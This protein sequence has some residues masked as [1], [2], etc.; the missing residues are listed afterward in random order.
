ME[1]IKAQEKDSMTLAILKKQ[2]WE[3]TYRGIYPNEK[4]DNFNFESHAEKFKK[5][6]QDKTK[7]VYLIN[8]ENENVGYFCIGTPKYPLGD[9]E[10]CINSLYI[11]QKCQR[12]GIGSKV[13][14]FIKNYCKENKI[15]KFFNG[16][17]YYNTKAQNFYEKMGGILFD[18]DLNHE[19]KSE[20][21]VYYKYE[22]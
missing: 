1:F 19:D 2:V 5:D 13:F 8:H 20:M 22:V 4:I 7:Q 14:E 6:I 18:K 3:E 10:M 15:T 11:L 16:C 17:N 21:Q 9:F 12:S